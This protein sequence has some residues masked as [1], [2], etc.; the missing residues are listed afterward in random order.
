MVLMVLVKLRALG[1]RSPNPLLPSLCGAGHAREMLGY[2]SKG[3]GTGTQQVKSVTRE[4]KIP[5]GAVGRQCSPRVCV[6]GEAWL[7]QGRTPRWGSHLGT[8]SDAASQG[9]A[10]RGREGERRIV[11]RTGLYSTLLVPLLLFPSSTG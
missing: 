11:L 1:A 9:W 6:W 8:L 4:G 2:R 10:S 5:W 7:E 3:L